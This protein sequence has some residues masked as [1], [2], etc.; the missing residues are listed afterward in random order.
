VT[1]I[2]ALAFFTYDTTHNVF[3]ISYGDV[4]SKTEYDDILGEKEVEFIMSSLDRYG[5]AVDSRFRE[6]LSQNEVER[7]DRSIQSKNTMKRNK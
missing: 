4:E 1:Q 3:C 7:L 5:Q 2:W 6:S